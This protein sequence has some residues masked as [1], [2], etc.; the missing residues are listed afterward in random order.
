MPIQ[1][2]LVLDLT[3]FIVKSE[4]KKSEVKKECKKDKDYGDDYDMYGDDDYG[5]YGDEDD[6]G[7]DDDFGKKD[8]DLDDLNII[9]SVLQVKEEYKILDFII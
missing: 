4:F 1:N 7:L 9:E 3:E 2:L 8:A 5:N 6:F